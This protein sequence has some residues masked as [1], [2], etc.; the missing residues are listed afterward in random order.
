MIYELELLALCDY[1]TDIFLDI[2]SIFEKQYSGKNTD[3]ERKILTK[4]ID[5]YPDV[6]DYD[7]DEKW[8]GF[9]L[10]YKSKYPEW[11]V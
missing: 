6:L 5:M 3:I 2:R 9:Q 1:D 4:F 10:K 8:G 11:F 7:F